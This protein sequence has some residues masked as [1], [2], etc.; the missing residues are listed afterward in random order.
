[1]NMSDELD[2]LAKRQAMESALSGSKH[3]KIEEIMFGS[4]E[5]DEVYSD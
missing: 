5:D 4:D 3:K 2:S 1:M